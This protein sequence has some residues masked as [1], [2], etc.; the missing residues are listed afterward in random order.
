MRKIDWYAA[1]AALMIATPMM[2]QGRGRNTDGIPPGQRPSA[3]MCRVWIDG[4]PPGRQPAETDC[5]TAASRVPRNG[6]VIYGANTQRMRDNLP[7]TDLPRANLPRTERN[8][9]D[10]RTENARRIYDQAARKNGVNAG[11]RQKYDDE[12]ADEVKHGKKAKHE[13]KSKHPGDN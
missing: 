8:A 5:A 10:A 1:A 12:K 4:V 6:R 7:R 9:R 11:D 3:G 2:A 13:K